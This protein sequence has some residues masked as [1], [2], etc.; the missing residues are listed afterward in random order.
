MEKVRHFKL[1]EKASTFVDPKSGLHIVNN[2]T[3]SIPH[4]NVRYSKAV[5]DALESGHI[6]E[7][8]NPGEEIKLEKK[9]K[10]KTPEETK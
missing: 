10:K 6:K 2:Q 3:I 9:K 5:K 4:K 7:V 1:G 8:E